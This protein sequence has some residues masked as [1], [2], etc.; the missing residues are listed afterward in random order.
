MDYSRIYNSLIT[1][2]RAR[3]PEGYT[4]EHHV[5]PLCCKGEDDESNLVKLY[6]EEHFLC[7]LLLVKMYPENRK[8]VYA[9]N[10]MCVANGKM[11]RMGN[12]RF[13]WLRR[14]MAKS[15]K[16]NLS[17]RRRIHKGVKARLVKPEE[18]C[19]FIGR[20]WKLGAVKRSKITI[21]RL[22]ATKQ[23]RFEKTVAS[24]YAAPQY[25]SICNAVLPYANP[26]TLKRR[27]RLKSN[28]GS[29]SCRSI[30]AAGYA[31]A[32]RQQKA[33]Q[34]QQEADRSLKTHARR[35]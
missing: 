21:E 15:T 23:K 11:S 28:C 27:E 18:L 10:M 13:G 29:T 14:K 24:Y 32:R 16:D 22:K 5:I 17:G 1:R 30:A 4:E 8:L 9:A 20:G 12:K 2:A 31:S 25:C 19:T 7:H 33:H 3:V 35:E 26:F 6:P 34:T